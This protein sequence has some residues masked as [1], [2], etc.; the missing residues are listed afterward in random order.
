MPSASGTNTSGEAKPRLA[1]NATP[2]NGSAVAPSPSA[3]AHQSTGNRG[4]F[5]SSSGITK[6]ERSEAIAATIA[7]PP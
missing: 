2:P 3:N 5:G 7:K 4:L 1:S 6:K